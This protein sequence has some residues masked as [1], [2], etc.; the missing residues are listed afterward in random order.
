MT[1]SEKR[2]RASRRLWCVVGALALVLPSGASGQDAPTVPK[3]L[4][5]ADAI[6]IALEGS[7]QVGSDE[8]QLDAARK[9]RSAALFALGPDLSVSASRRASTTTQ[10]GVVIDSMTVRDVEEETKSTNYNASSSVRLFDGLANFAR[11]SAAR[12]DVRADEHALAY[13]RQQ[14]QENVVSAYYNLMRAQLLLKVAEEAESVAREQLERTQALYELGSAA[15]SDVLK[16]QVQH[17][18]TRLELVRA[19]NNERQSHVDLEFTMN[20]T[21]SV[22]FEIDTTVTQIGDDQVDYESERARALTDRENLLSL[23]HRERAADR[24]V[25]AARGALLPTVDFQYSLSR[26]RN[27]T[28][29]R[30][31]GEEQ[32]SRDW[33]FF[34]NWNIWDRYQNYANIAQARASAR[35]SEFS[36]RQA[37]LDA[38]R[39]VRQLV[40]SLGEARERLAVAR[41]NVARSREDLRL[42]QEKFR[43]GAGTIL[44]TITAESDLTSTRANEVQAVVDFLIARAN[45]A[46]ATGRDFSEL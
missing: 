41:E 25:W 8:A 1:R 24:R 5:L 27:P 16:S 37:E 36:R 21:T 31:G 9:A 3:L 26:S 39:E 33:A 32:D 17:G 2:R 18:N 20:L 15:R 23:R 29:F 45:L 22:E 14:V 35:Q 13:T 28:R 30:V 40:N 4:R 34:A 10:K 19:R 43:V 42:A 6:R 44:D 38:I 46:R 12:H 7:T 11:L